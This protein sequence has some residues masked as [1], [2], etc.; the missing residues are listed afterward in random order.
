MANEL[1]VI[2]N[3][4][5]VA[6]E[7]AAILLAAFGAPFEEAGEILATYKD[8]KVTDV[9]DFST[10]AEAR[11]L[12]LKLKEIRVIV[13]KK[14][15]ELKEDSLRT[16]KAIDSVA[17]KVKE[18][19]EPAEKYLEE[20]EKFAEIKAAE[21]KAK[22]TTQRLTKLA[23]YTTD[24]TV[25]SVEDM[26]VEQFDTL[27]AGLEAQKQQLIK[28]EKEAEAARLAEIEAEKKRQAEIE[29]ENVKLKAEAEAREKSLEKEREAE[30]KKQAEIDAKKDAELKAER[31]KTEAERLKREEVERKQREQEE[32]QARIKA[33]AEEKERQALLSPDK[34]KLIAFAN[35]LDIIRRE[36]LPAVKTKQ[37]QEVVDQIDTALADLSQKLTAKAKQL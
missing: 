30:R 6:K 26:S 23:E 10:M 33:E 35:A 24:V 14:R 1:Q 20:Q 19:I 37:A 11:D 8:L 32:I 34:D 22:V 18:E 7:N 17:K 15:K 29:A 9:N 28:E 4:Q 16:G 21:A 3:E 5:Q 31:E 13:E 36:K 12:R 27:V 25:Y 2:L